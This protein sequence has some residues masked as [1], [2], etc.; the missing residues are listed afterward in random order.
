[1]GESAT[2]EVEASGTPPLTYQWQRDGED[3]DGADEASYT[4]DDAQLSDDGAEFSVVVSNDEG[5]AT[6]DAATLHVVEDERPIAEI[7]APALYSGGETI[8]YDGSGSSDPEDGDLTYT[9][10][11]DFHHEVH[12]HPF[13][14]AEEGP[15]TGEFTAPT[16]GHT[17]SDVWFRVHL[18]VTDEAGLEDSAFRD[19]HPRL[20]EITLAANVPGVQ[21]QLDG[22]PQTAPHA[23]DSVVGVERPIGAPT[24]QTVAGKTYDFVSW[25]DG[26]AP[27]H[28]ISTPAVD[29][30]YTATFRERGSTT[31]PPGPG[32]GGGGAGPGANPLVPTLPAALPGPRLS[33]RTPARMRW[34]GARRRGIPVRVKGVAGASVRV[35]VLRGRRRLAVKTVRVGTAGERLIRVKL[36]RG[37][38]QRR[39]RVRIVVEATL[40]DGRVLTAARRLTLRPSS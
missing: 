23:V 30:T 13:L 7:E 12:S 38:Q 33:L 39:R 29:T 3:I 21:L 31:P 1:V 32:T 18:T 36:P 35:L 5:D 27:T 17:A 19:V 34:R 25:S 20:A 26:G 2:F 6:S 16:T 28:T 24:P 10:Q 4:L 22:Q 14:P 40:P 8:A 37:A 15:A 11:V 9:W